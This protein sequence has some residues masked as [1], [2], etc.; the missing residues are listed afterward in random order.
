MKPT[1]LNPN[2]L[3]TT[4]EV[5]ILVKL[6]V[7]L[8]YLEPSVSLVSQAIFFI[9][10]TVSEELSALKKLSRIK[11]SHAVLIDA[12][13]HFLEIH[14][15]MNVWMN[16]CI[17]TSNFRLILYVSANALNLTIYQPIKPAKNVQ[18]IHANRF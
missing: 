18:E 12:L 3:T 9:T 11:I 13:R 17:I 2:I 14:S 8:V 15:C 10:R 6:P 1:V 7:R 4:L 16:A 5:A